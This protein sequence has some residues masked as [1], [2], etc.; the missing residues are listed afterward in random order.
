MTVD[1][2]ERELLAEFLGVTVVRLDINRALEEEPF[3]QT[4]E[5]LLDGLGRTLGRRDPSRTVALRA[6]QICSTDSFSRRM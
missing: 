6:F 5:L 2:R 1:P 4:V 3:V